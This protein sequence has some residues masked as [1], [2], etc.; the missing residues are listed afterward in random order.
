MGAKTKQMK[1]RI[2]QAAGSL[3]GNKRL[4]REGKVDRQSGE[5]TQRLNQAAGKAEEVIDKA[6]AAVKEAIGT[7]RNARRRK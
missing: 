5:A 2:K 6:A 4:E 3:V 7:G 1:G